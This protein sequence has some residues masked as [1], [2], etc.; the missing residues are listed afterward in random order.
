MSLKGRELADGRH[1]HQHAK[2]TVD[3]GWDTRQQFNRRTY[4]FGQNRIGGLRE[5][6]GGQQ[7]DW[8]TDNNRA[9][10]SR[11]RRKDHRQD[12][13]NL[14]ACLPLCAEQKIPHTDLDQGGSAGDKDI[15]CNNSYRADGY[16]G[17]DLKNRLGQTLGSLGPKRQDRTG[18]SKSQ[19]TKE[20]PEIMHLYLA[21]IER[22]DRR[23]NAGSCNQRD[24]RRY[25]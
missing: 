21:D 17:K 9:Q 18:D 16:T 7:A 14:R 19:C 6:D 10:S 23:L 22:S 2:K 12:A 5:K 15:D 25:S 4:N 8:H 13:K 11:N 20:R 24:Q 3:D 1:N